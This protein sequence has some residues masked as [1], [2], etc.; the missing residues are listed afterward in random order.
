[1]LRERESLEFARALIE[2]FAR[3]PVDA[4]L[5][6]AAGC[7]SHLKDAG[8]DLPVLDI[9][10]ALVAGRLA[11]PYSHKHPKRGFVT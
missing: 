1:M 7:G 2:R 4:I 10:E 8:L 5:V 9:S 3:E 6:N 11:A